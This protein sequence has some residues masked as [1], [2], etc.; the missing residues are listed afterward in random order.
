[1]QPALGPSQLHAAQELRSS[2][3][4]MNLEVLRPVASRKLAATGRETAQHGED[5][6]AQPAGRWYRRPG[7][8]ANRSFGTLHVRRTRPSGIWPGGPVG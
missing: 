3:I 1:M 8:R 7:Q 5:D 4:R 2:L 6:P